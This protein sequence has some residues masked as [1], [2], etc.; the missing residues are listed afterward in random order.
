MQNSFPFSPRITRSAN[1][2]ACQNYRY[3]L[4]RVWAPTQ[5]CVLFIGLNPS[6]ADHRQDDPTI[7]RCMNFAQ[8]WGFGGLLM[9]NLFAYR[10][11]DPATLRLVTDPI[12]PKNDAWILKMFKA[13]D[14]VVAAW[15]ND[16]AYM[17]RSNVIRHLCPGLSVLKLNRSGEPAHP[18]YLKASLEPKP[19]T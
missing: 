1:F 3:S 6:T 15:G 7:R 10:S 5:K 13:S 14:L 11:T 4:Q 12:G 16:G 17:N 9:A 2:S 18:L 19:W 8:T